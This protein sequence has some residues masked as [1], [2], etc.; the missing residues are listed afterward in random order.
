MLILVVL[1]LLDKEIM[2]ELGRQLLTQALVVVV[3]LV[4]LEVQHL[5]QVMVAMVVLEPHLQ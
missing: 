2:A 4:L 3:V 5:A 1:E